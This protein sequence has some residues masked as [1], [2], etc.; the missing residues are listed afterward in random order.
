MMCLISN[1]VIQASVLM[2]FITG[3]QRRWWKSMYGASCFTFVLCA[4]KMYFFW[5]SYCGFRWAV[6]CV[7]RSYNSFIRAIRFI[8][9]ILFYYQSK[10]TAGKRITAARVVLMF[11]NLSFELQYVLLYSVLLFLMSWDER[12][13]PRY[14][15]C[16]GFEITF[17]TALNKDGFASHNSQVLEYSY[18]RKTAT[19]IYESR[20]LAGRKV[21]NV[22]FV[23]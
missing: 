13:V 4:L 1:G 19:Q 11:V 23:D 16:T 9:V 2:P 12:N 3:T 8:T 15:F 5:L 21:Q 14:F 10:W 18:P 7:S 17:I 6:A 20:M 22:L